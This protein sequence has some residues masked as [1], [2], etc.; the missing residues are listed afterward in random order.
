MA[1]EFEEERHSG[2]DN[3]LWEVHKFG[4][5]SVA[6]AS[7]FLKV[8]SIVEEQLRIPTE[9]QFLS[10]E[11]TTGS[12]PSIAVVVLDGWPPGGGDSQARMLSP[13]LRWRTVRREVR[14]ELFSATK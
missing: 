2:F 3:K 5:T 1:F 6:D 10:V 7:C 4:G 12:P 13:T 11:P 8:A 9:S 14:R